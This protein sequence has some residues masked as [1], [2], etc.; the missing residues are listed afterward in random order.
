LRTDLQNLLLKIEKARSNDLPFVIYKMPDSDKVKALF[1]GDDKLCFTKDLSEPGFVFSPF[2]D[3]AQTIVFPFKSC[4][5]YVAPIRN[6]DEDANMEITN[7]TYEIRGESLNLKMLSHINLVSKGI[8]HIKNGHL[9]KVVLSRKEEIKLNAF[10]LK[11]IFKKLLFK[12]PTTF[13]YCWFH[14]QVGLWLGATPETLIKIKGNNFKTMALASTQVYNGSLEVVWGDKEIQEQQ[15]V[16]DFITS[17]LAN[18]HIKTSKP[19]TLQAGSL[20]HI[21]SEIS[22]ELGSKDELFKL[23]KVLHPTPAVC[24]LPKLEAKEFILKNE[25][26][27]REFYT[28]FLGE[29]HMHSLENER[30]SIKSKETNLFVNLRCMQI[31][32]KNAILYVGGGITSN[33]DPLKEWEETVSKSKIMKRV[34]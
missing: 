27:Q 6:F 25:V 28:G 8:D 5:F 21:C 3:D 33:S 7:N 24:G 2:D 23:V 4:S 20:L 32:N 15:F 10:D 9:S 12:Y 18:S 30:D 34:L 19:F 31:K 17:N 26:Y 29:I 14:P 16:T 11:N 1:Q 13:V 22:G